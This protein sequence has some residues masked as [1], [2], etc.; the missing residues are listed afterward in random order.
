M[1]VTTEGQPAFKCHFWPISILP[2]ISK[3]LKKN[4]Y[5]QVTLYF[6]SHNIVPECQSGF[7]KGHSI[8]TAFTTILDGAIDNGE[9]IILTMFDFSKALDIFNHVLLCTF[10]KCYGFDNILLS[11]FKSFL[12]Y[13]FQKVVI[14]DEELS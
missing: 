12:S 11:L 7:R 5:I 6:D 2:I 8:L 9:A 10:L 3:I 4:I 1:V 14:N 13:I